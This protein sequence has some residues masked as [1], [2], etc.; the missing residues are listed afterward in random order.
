MIALRRPPAKPPNPPRNPTSGRRLSPLKSVCWM[1]RTTRLPLR[2][3]NT[4]YHTRYKFP[5]DAPWSRDGCSLAT[6]ADLQPSLPPAESMKGFT[7]RMVVVVV[8]MEAVPVCAEQTGS[9]CS[10]GAAGQR[11]PN[12][13][14]T[15]MQISCPM[16]F[17]GVRWYLAN[18]PDPK[19][20]MEQ[21]EGFGCVS[22]I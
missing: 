13:W 7:C 22:E 1:D 3:A 14:S 4:L 20:G 9:S 5:P 11:S 19:E 12:L 8:S 6:R 16:G 21:S 18:C 10:T 17:G 2:C 15:R